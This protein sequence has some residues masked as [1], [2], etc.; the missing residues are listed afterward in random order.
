[1]TARYD[2]RGA[3]LALFFAI[4]AALAQPVLAQAQRVTPVATA[5]ADP[6]DQRI[7]QRIRAIFT[8]IPDLAAVEVRVAAGVVTLGGKVADDAD[9]AQAE[10]IA[11]KISGVVTVRNLLVRDLAVS[12]NLNPALGGVKD[13]AAQFAQVLPLAA[14]AILVALAIGYAGYFV[15]RRKTFFQRIAPNPFLA[16]LMATAV[17][18]V[19]VVGGIVLA[20][21]IVGATALLGAVLGGAGV[22][23]IAVGVAMRDTIENYVS[24]LMLSIR[25]PFRANDHVRIDEHEG[26]VVRLTTRATV[27]MT[28]DGN[29]LRIPNSTVFKAVILNF[30]TNPKRRFTFDMT[31]D[32][33]ADPCRARD[34]GM[35]AL[36]KLEFLLDQP[37]AKAEVV[38]MPGTTQ[39]IRFYGW[40]DQTHVD[41]GKAR[42]LAFETVRAA[43]RA[44]CFILPDATYHVVIDKDAPLAAPIPEEAPDLDVSA[45]DVAP[46]RQI[47]KMVARERAGDDEGQDLLSGER[48]TE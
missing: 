2:L 5:T 44:E 18:F 4:S 32:H 33:T 3:L 23:G 30:T 40:V 28:L 24:S 6:E 43:L 8:E 31:L 29:H 22:I 17:R 34:A 36:R 9:I 41:H 47:E 37:P 21:D 38:E 46:E 48:P 42:T 10:A 19:F 20:L 13:K 1:M 12:R 7:A 27:L 45:D 15:A 35:T 16:E 26:R 14:I 25:Q 39:V 11:A